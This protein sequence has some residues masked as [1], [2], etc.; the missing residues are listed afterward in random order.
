M[1]K[2]Q[3]LQNVCRCL[4]LHLLRIGSASFAFDH[5]PCARMIWILPTFLIL[6]RCK[7]S[8][9]R[10]QHWICPCV[11]RI[12]Q[13][14]LSYLPSLHQI[15]TLEKT[16]SCQHSILS[17]LMSDRTQWVAP[18]HDVAQFAGSQE[19]D[20]HVWCS[21]VFLMQRMLAHQESFR[22]IVRPNSSA[23]I[24]LWLFLH[25]NLFAIFS[26]SLQNNWW[27]WNGQFWTNTKDGPTHHVWNFPLSMMSASLFLVSMCLIW[28]LESKLIRSNCLSRTTLWVLETCLNVRLLPIVIILITA[29]L[30][31]NTYNKAFW[32]EE[33]HV[34]RNKINIVQIID[35]IVW[36]VENKFAVCSLTSRPVLFGAESCFQQQK[37]LDPTLPEQADHPISVQCP[38]RQFQIL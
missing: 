3:T 10:F 18:F 25:L 29:S 2:T 12:Q 15:S 13:V 20:F 5:S 28:I 8:S 36:E 33:L 30:S 19:T 14:A 34:W 32:W 6:L 37:I 9:Y 27:N 22:C 1:W 24:L 38:K 35:H 17:S 7:N 21:P 26:T 16:N 11:V 4:L 31:P 23:S